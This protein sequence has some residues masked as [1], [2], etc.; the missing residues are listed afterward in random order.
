[1]EISVRQRK[2]RKNSNGRTDEN[3]KRQRSLTVWGTSFERQL[4][5][6]NPGAGNKKITERIPQEKLQNGYG[7]GNCSTRTVCFFSVECCID[8][9]KNIA[10]SYSQYRM[11]TV[12]W[13]ALLGY[14]MTNT[15]WHTVWEKFSTR[16]AHAPDFRPQAAYAAPDGN[17]ELDAGALLTSSFHFVALLQLS[18]HLRTNRYSQAG[19]NVASCAPA[20]IATRACILAVWCLEV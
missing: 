10:V 20:P 1:M 8:T 13:M 11:R 6:S 3:N 17:A 2:W 7:K 18:F 16:E 5:G 12:N 14:C 19:P 15:V 9:E 4:A